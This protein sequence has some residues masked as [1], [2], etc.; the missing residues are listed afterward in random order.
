MFLT[1]LFQEHILQIHF[2]QIPPT[3]VILGR[4]ALGWRGKY[5]FCEG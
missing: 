2:S 1:L 4:E 3:F 5:Y